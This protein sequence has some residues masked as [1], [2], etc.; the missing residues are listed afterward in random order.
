MNASLFVL[1]LASL[2]GGPPDVLYDF[3]STNCGPCQMMMPI[4][5]RL[6][7]EGW[8]VVKINVDER[9]DFREW[10]GVQRWPTFILIVGGREQQRLTG[11]QDESTL[12]SLLA[13]IPRRSSGTLANRSSQPPRPRRSLPVR[14]A[15]DESKPKWD[16]HLN[17]PSLP[18]RN[19]KQEVV[20]VDP[21]APPVS[22]RARGAADL[23]GQRN[24][25]PDSTPQRPSSTQ[26]AA[27]NVQAEAPPSSRQGADRLLSSSVRI[28]VKDPD[29][30]YFGS[31]VAI[32]SVPGKTLVLT[33]GHILRDA[34]PGSHIEVDLFE[35]NRSRTY[36][37]SIVKS[38]ADADVGLIV[39]ATPAV[40]PISTV[41]GTANPLRADDPVA[42][43]GCSGGELPSVER[44]RVT[45]LN[46]Y[47]G[48]DTI[49]CT[50][51]PSEGRS[52]GGLFNRQ[53]E[54]V[55]I[56]TNA[57][58]NE[59]RGVY[60]G[61]RPVHELLRSAGLEALI[62]ETKDAGER[63]AEA[64]ASAKSDPKGEPMTKPENSDEAAPAAPQRNPEAVAS[65]SA[66]DGGR[67][68]RVRSAAP[69]NDVP[70][71]ALSS[72]ASAG[73][74]ASSETV[75]ASST[76]LPDLSKAMEQAE[77]ICII[78]PINQ[79]RGNSRVV[80]I[81][82]ASRKFMAY[83]N[84]E[85]KDRLRP[86]MGR[87]SVTAAAPDRETAEQSRI[88]GNASTEEPAAPR[89]T[90]AWKPATSH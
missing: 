37:A 40:V 23:S 81:N 59:L 55:G 60:A 41:A 31:G 2:A 54:V 42:S 30:A 29:G 64:S 74:T 67:L 52:G 86:A 43:I 6:Q 75:A 38:D 15:D 65:N 73:A 71:Q 4:V 46:R 66:Q 51:V 69:R 28:R 39:I 70:Q 50:G 90:A 79:P 53:G 58:P 13:Q 89:N 68:R 82:R 16:F 85:S 36:R 1:S 63:L 32:D 34:K 33:C 77:V 18:G 35:G 62:P 83:L 47:L 44:L 88:R 27:D 19:R 8:P 26:P 72:D 5:E 21:P 17:L 20:Q 87:T 25:A 78:R 14:L 9:P 24:A 11:M 48:P 49:E 45:A 76:D 80:I 12:R 3:Y 84:G 56:C 61:L 7:A 10:Y 22:N 57:D